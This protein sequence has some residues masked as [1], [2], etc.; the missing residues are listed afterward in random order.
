MN[1]LTRLHRLLAQK[2]FPA[3]WNRVGRAHPLVEIIGLLGLA[4]VA[5]A[6]ALGNT[7][8][9]V[10]MGLLLIASLFA[11][12]A[13]WTGL[14]SDW[15][16][17]FALIWFCFVL[18]RALWGSWEMPALASEHLDRT[19]NIA[20]VL[21]F[22]LACWWL[23]GDRR[24]VVSLCAVVLAGAVAGILYYGNW[25]GLDVFTIPQRLRFGGDPRLQGL[26]YVSIL[27]GMIAFARAWWGSSVNRTAF[28]L[29]ALLWVLLY[30]L[31]LWALIAVQARAAWIAGALVGSIFF[32]CFIWNKL[33]RHAGGRRHELAI[34]LSFLVSTSAVLAIFA[35]TIANRMLEEHGHYELVIQGEVQEIED[36]SV[37]TRLYLIGVGWSTW[38]DRPFFGWGPGSSE[39]LIAHGD[40]PG[41]LQGSAELHNNYLDVLMRFGMVGTL[42]FFG[43]WSWLILRTLRHVRAGDIPADVGALGLS[44]SLI[45]FIVNFTDTYIDFQFGWFYMLLLCALL[46]SPLMR[47]GAAAGRIADD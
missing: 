17:R 5:F 38:L 34:G 12:R 26:L 25:H 42:L 40:M 46:H 47:P 18:L 45:F 29:R 27:A 31:I 30:L 39:Y 35:D 28:F 43:F 36:R 33:R 4:L 9:S 44:V 6:L 11:W 7:G 14:K 8:Q 10:G 24:A 22:P 3:R 15:V 21:L 37:A 2:V 23:G 41:E 32:I 19:R 13:L 20:R 16:A 1:V